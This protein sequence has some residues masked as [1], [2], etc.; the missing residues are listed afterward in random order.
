MYRDF[1]RIKMALMVTFAERN[2]PPVGSLGKRKSV[3]DD[4][5]RLCG[6]HLRQVKR[7]AYAARLLM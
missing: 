5:M 1:A 7:L 3:V 2:S 6:R 4:V